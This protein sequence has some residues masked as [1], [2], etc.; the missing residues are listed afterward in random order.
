MMIKH[1]ASDR[2]VLVFVSLWMLLVGQLQVGQ[3]YFIRLTNFISYHYIQTHKE[4]SLEVT[5]S[6]G[7]VLPTHPHFILLLFVHTELGFGAVVHNWLLDLGD[8]MKGK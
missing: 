8:C 1:I 6:L 5:S 7:E 3:Y 2:L 4:L